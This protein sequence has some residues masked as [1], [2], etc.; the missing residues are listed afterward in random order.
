MHIHKALGDVIVRQFLKFSLPKS[1][2]RIYLDYIIIS[3]PLNLIIPLHH[4][5]DLGAK[6]C[7]HSGGPC[8]GRKLCSEAR[9]ESSETGPQWYRPSSLTELFEILG[10]NPESKI[11]L[12]AGDTGRGTCEERLKHLSSLV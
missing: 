9:L 3:S 11:K 5:Q 7:P 8:R 6:V 12:L 4:T 10:N 2:H 1:C